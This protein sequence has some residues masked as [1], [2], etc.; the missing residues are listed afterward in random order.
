MQET[1]TEIFQYNDYNLFVISSHNP[2]LVMLSISIAILASYM[3]FQVASQASSTS[4]IR[5]HISLLIGS[6][7]LGGGVW[8]MHF[9]GMLALELCTKVSYQV[10]LTAVSILPAIAASWIALN[11]ITREQLKLQQLIIGGVLVGAGIGTMHYAGMAAME[12]APLLRYNLAM[13][14]LSILVAVSLAILS[15]WISFGLNHNKASML[16][17]NLKMAISSC[18]MGAAISGMH[19][20]GMAAAR[21]VLPP[22][23][24]LSKQTSEIS[25]YLAIVITGITV[26]I[27]LLVLA[28]NL[29][30]SYK[31][32]SIAA[33]NNERRLLATMD[34]ATDGII[35]LSS[36][37]II[38]SVNKAVTRLLGWEPEELI[39]ADIKM[40]VPPPSQGDH[41]QY[42]NQFLQDQ[43]TKDSNTD[44]E[45]N[46]LTKS[47]ETI[48]VRLGIGRVNLNEKHLFVAFISDLRERKKMENTLREKETKIRSLITN[49]PGIAYRCIDKPGWPNVFINDEVEK[50]IGYPAQDFLLPEPTRS[51]S[52]FVHPE[53]MI[54]ISELDLRDPDGYKLE[55]RIIDRYGTVKWMLGHGRAIKAEKSDEYYLDGFIMDITERKVME[56]ALITAK[57]QA[58]QAAESR[59]AFLANMSHEI[60]TP[61]NAII[62]FSD[63]L[64]DEKLTN[65]QTKQLNTI[66]QSARSLL[67]ILN[68]V[69]DSAKLDKGK[70]QLEYRDFSLVEE[71]DSV[72]STLW[73][74]AQS[75]GVDINLNIEKIAQRFY[76]GAPDRIRQVLTNILGNAIKFTEKGSVTIDIKVIEPGFLNFT[77]SDTGIGMTP[78]QLDT[79]FDAFA[80]AD[81]SM[82]RRFGGTGLGTTISKQLVELMGGTIS[83]S[84]DHGKGSVF[85][86]NLPLKTAE[87]SLKLRIKK[88]YADL[89]K[90]NILV[91][92]DIEQ[93]LDLLSLILKRNNHEVSIAKNG[94]QA[95]I[96]MEN[97]LFDIVLMDIQMP[98]MDGLT[99]A[100][101]R[102]EFE[103]TN[104]L[105]TLPII[106]LTAS[107]L[108]QDRQ[109]AEQAG[110]NGFANKPIDIKQL[111]E[112]IA[113]ILSPTQI[114]ATKKDGNTNQ[115]LSID[116][117]K[118]I[119]LWETKT[120]L[121]SEIKR[122]IQQSEKDVTSL[123]T[124]VEKQEW[125]I[126]EGIAHK[127]KGVSGNLALTKLM[128]VLGELEQASR[129]HTENDSLL[130]I[131]NIKREIES[132]THCVNKRANQVNVPSEQTHESAVSHTKISNNVSIDE[133]LNILL[134]LEKHVK[135]N[136]FDE[137][138]LDKLQEI[139]STYTQEIN[140]IISACN[141]FEFT[142]ALNHI[143]ALIG[144]LQSNN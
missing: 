28:V 7:A 16:S 41:D 141:D 139:K 137:S 143:E 27:I 83:A 108:P 75:K 11:L 58:E 6:I 127:L 26:V 44:Q 120:T 86:F 43:K 15:L 12:M 132:I 115:Q 93:N 24:E 89:P 142:L 78:Q 107:V 55:F 25:T 135:N 73:L 33:L 19:Y 2:W 56:S 104:Q 101:K 46:A 129:Q 13:F 3:G 61:M 4:T 82:S 36:R 124:L 22:G 94:E 136:E 102:R 57:E 49:I 42:I 105:P 85:T 37:G 8:S 90:L 21:F 133:L 81:E 77:V 100:K 92:D 34:T 128:L 110:M 121:F 38:I 51:I 118:G 106:A 35:T 84:S 131:I 23:L 122:F 52:E 70:F 140:S 54:T 20:T 30:F 64:L 109:S 116:I 99:A 66:N 47:G 79:I 126:V 71:V 10:E 17:D 31:D 68:D 74:Q 113:G 123:K 69:L 40:M 29:L 96:A 48:P 65:N 18:V 111:M 95:L 125:K 91:V 138:L 39:G 80:Q 119:L 98:V 76:N 97:S 1:I 32:K 62:G 59:S 112:E 72:V 144:S 53:D 45:V 63:L 14:G 117:E 87:P 60:R 130:S 134:S 114:K 103:L 67:H 50:I 5:K 9:I 88:T